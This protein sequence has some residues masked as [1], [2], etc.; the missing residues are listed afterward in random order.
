MRQKGLLV[1]GKR[2]KQRLKSDARWRDLNV[3]RG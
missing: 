1:G 2:D 3:F